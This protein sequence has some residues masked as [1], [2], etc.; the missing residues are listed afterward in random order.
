MRVAGESGGDGDVEGG[1]VKGG[2][3]DLFLKDKIGITGEPSCYTVS[4]FFC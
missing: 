4:V 2:D 1:D 3:V